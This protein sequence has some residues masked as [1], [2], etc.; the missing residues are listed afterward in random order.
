MDAS[1]WICPVMCASCLFMIK[2]T[3]L[4]AL[5]FTNYSS[6]CASYCILFV[7]VR[8][9]WTK[10]CLQLLYFYY[11]VK[12]FFL[13]LYLFIILWNIECNCCI[14]I[15]LWKKTRYCCT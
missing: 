1:V 15:M 14:F 6:A 4:F 12:N 13:L 5:P 2:F 8:E 3:T 7:F 11:I 9:R 10:I